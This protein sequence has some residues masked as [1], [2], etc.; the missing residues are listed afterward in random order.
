MELG[1]IVDYCIEYNNMHDNKRSGSSEENYNA[2]N[3][4]RVRKATQADWDAFAG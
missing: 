2:H 1:A 3:E 4:P